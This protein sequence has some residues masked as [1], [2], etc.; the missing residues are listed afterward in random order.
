MVNKVILLGHLCADPEV[1]VTPDGTHVTSMR[2]ATNQFRARDQ[3]GN[4]QEITQF[5]RIVLFGRLAE[6]AGSYL[7]K[8]RLVYTEG[9]LQHTSWEGQDGQVR[10]RSE[11]VAS[12]LH[13][14]GPRPDGGGSADEH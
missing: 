3:E 4:R 11:V 13:L 10:Y 7:R 12:T 14:V 6:I 1:R 9:Y 8:G 5:H 2:V